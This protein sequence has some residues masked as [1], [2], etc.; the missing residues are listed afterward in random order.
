[1]KIESLSLALITL[2]SEMNRMPDENSGIEGLNNTVGEN[3][4]KLS[5][6]IFDIED[7]IEKMETAEEVRKLLS[8][9]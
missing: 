5:D 9:K 2:K 6:A 7:T 1:M 3:F 4:R 8:G